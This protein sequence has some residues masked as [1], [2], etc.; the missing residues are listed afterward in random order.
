MLMKDSEVARHW[1]T[2]LQ[3]EFTTKQRELTESSSR[4]IDKNWETDSLEGA[5]FG[6][7]YDTN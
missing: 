5:R 2:M 7:R 4:N 1:S 6:T 3:T